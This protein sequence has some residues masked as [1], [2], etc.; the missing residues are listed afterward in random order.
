M[1]GVV[2]AVIGVIILAALISGVLVFWA[3]NTVIPQTF[4]LP[5]INI[6]QGFALAL[7]GGSI[8]KSYNTKT[9]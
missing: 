9:N 3:W 7:L 4:G 6:V 2:A 5:E 1:L 8:F